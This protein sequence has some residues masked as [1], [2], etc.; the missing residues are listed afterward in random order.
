MTE[1]AND[2]IVTSLREQITDNDRA[3]V[4]AVNQRLR[5]VAQLQDHKAARNYERVD[6]ARE[7]WLVSHL[8]NENAGPLSDDGL[9]E[10]VA[11]L[12]N[13]TKRELSFGTPASRHRA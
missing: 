5:L 6:S 2:P 10:L 1:I 12:L 7:D 9:R 3:I 13:L 8:A 4:E 11:A